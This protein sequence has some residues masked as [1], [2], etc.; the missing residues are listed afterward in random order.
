MRAVTCVLFLLLVRQSSVHAGLADPNCDDSDCGPNRGLLGG[1][2]NNRACF[3]NGNVSAVVP[4]NP[5]M[6]L[7]R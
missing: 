6:S 3:S 7:W 2:G 1:C 4:S 5:L